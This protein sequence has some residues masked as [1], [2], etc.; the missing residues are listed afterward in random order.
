MSG[1]GL[2][3]QRRSAV[4]VAFKIPESVLVV[5][6]TPALRT[7]LLERVEQPAFW[8]SVT[9]SLAEPGEPL[10]A[11]C[12]REVQEET[13]WQAAAC[14]FDD[15]GIE[16]EFAIYRQWLHRYAPGV[17]RNREH[18]FGLRVAQTFEARLS[19]REHTRWQWLPWREAADACFS[20]TNAKAIRMLAERPSR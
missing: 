8:Q 5:I 7:L 11:A 19:P 2:V 14:D 18:V 6:Y 12:A 15:W 13:G 3:A 1:S 16:N 20:W 4:E 10:A 9:G 17:T